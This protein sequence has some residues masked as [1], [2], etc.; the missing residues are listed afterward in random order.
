MSL[1]SKAGLRSLRTGKAKGRKVLV[2]STG[3]NVLSGEGD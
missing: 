3:G 1:V 2:I